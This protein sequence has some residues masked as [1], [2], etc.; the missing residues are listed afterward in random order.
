MNTYK[1][2]K[3][4][5]KVYHKEHG[6]GIVVSGNSPTNRVRIVEIAYRNGRYL[7]TMQS[8]LCKANDLELI[9]EYKTE[10]ETPAEMLQYLS[11]EMTALRDAMEQEIKDL[12][13]YHTEQAKGA[14]MVLK[15]YLSRCNEVLSNRGG[16]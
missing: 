11:S 1:I 2:F 16:L 15:K 6:N 4:G 5:D 9:N 3:K 14:Q 7:P 10:E 13:Q 8:R 12:E